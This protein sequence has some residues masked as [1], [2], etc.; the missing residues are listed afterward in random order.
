MTEITRDTVETFRQLRRVKFKLPADGETTD[1]RTLAAAIAK[2]PQA[3]CVLNVRRHAF[4]SWEEL[5][6]ILVSDE[7]DTVFH[8]SSAMC[9]QHRFDLLGDDQNPAAA[10]IR[11]RLRTGQPAASSRRN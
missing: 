5:R 9:A 7:R 10:T 3:L 4:E 6:N 8:L 11:H 2:R 1:W